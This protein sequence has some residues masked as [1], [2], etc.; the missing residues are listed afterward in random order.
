MAVTVTPQSGLSVTV[1]LGAARVVTTQT[2]SAIV[3]TTLDD[4]STVNT[5]GVQ[6]GYTLV[7]NSSTNKW[8]EQALVAAAPT[9]IDGGTY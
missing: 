3:G 2:S 8:T 7:Y 6:D 1:G 9:T 4:L 5:S